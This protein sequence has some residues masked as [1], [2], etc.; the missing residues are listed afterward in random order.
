[1]KGVSPSVRW[2][3]NYAVRGASTGSGVVFPVSFFL[4]VL[5]ARFC[6]KMGIH[7]RMQ[8]NYINEL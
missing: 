2:K 7:I 4:V 3:L 8:T 6:A 5:I 1:M